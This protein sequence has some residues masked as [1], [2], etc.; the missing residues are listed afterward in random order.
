MIK[1]QYLGMSPE[2]V[3]GF[4]AGIERTFEGALHLKPRKVFELTEEEYAHV[5][6]VRPDLRF[7]EF[8][9]PKKFERSGI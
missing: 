8:A 6:K 3:G 5:K 1:V 7:Q 2:D 9:A 4:P